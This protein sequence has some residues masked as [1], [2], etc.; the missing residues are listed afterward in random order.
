[1]I[2]AEG[3]EGLA[4]R[5]T[6]ITGAS[7]GIGAATAREFARLGA[8][9]VITSRS[10][11]TAEA[12]AHAIARDFSD[13]LLALELD[14]TSPS[15]VRR[16]IEDTLNW[17]TGELSVLVNNAGLPVVETLW[18]TPFHQFSEDELADEFRR[19]YAVDV[20][21]ARAVT[22]AV[23]P[24]MM[25]KRD[26]AVVFI[27]STPA[28]A[29]HHATPYTEAKAALLGLM[30]DTAL[31]YARFNI[32]ANAVAPGNIRTSWFDSLNAERQEELRREAPLERWGDPEEVARTI[33]FFASPQSSFVTGQTLVVDGGR[34]IH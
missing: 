12:T 33:A 27:S 21:G 6:L 11:A 25:G 22:R 26:G 8:R 14:V 10:L 29:G 16:C 24:T 18:D 1:M 5:V 23:L 31:N 20:V 3:L 34:I 4:G 13:D 17:S 7:Q 2:E 28:L 15:S 32:R 19:V 30:R 9:V